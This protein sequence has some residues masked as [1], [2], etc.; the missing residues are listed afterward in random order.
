[1]DT[2]LFCKIDRG[3][4][5]SEKVYDEGP[6]FA[7]KDINPQAPTHILIIPKKHYATILEIK[8]QDEPLIGSVYTV[9]N[10]LAQELG[11]AQSGFRVVLNCGSEAG[12]T[13]FHIH[14][15][16]LGGRAMTWPPG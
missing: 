8:T 16:L 15:H 1:M 9:A 2:C 12:Q 4:I 6:L 14:F 3:E 11:L 7:I 13:V 5:P 10:K